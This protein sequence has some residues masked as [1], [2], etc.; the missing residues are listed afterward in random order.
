MVQQYHCHTQC[1]TCGAAVSVMFSGKPQQSQDLQNW[2]C[3]L[4]ARPPPRASCLGRAP[5]PVCG[6]VWDLQWLPSYLLAVSPTPFCC[7]S[8]SCSPLPQFPVK[9]GEQ[10]SSGLNTSLALELLVV[11]GFQTVKQANIRRQRPPFVRASRQAL[12]GHQCGPCSKPGD[13]GVQTTGTQSLNPLTAPFRGCWFHHAAMQC[14]APEAVQLSRNHQKWWWGAFQSAGSALQALL[15][16]P[17]ACERG[18][19]GAERPNQV[20]T[21]KVR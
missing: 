21:T 4:V 9:S 16:A 11:L 1:Y 13:P 12:I 6:T 20:Q 15:L 18:C 3:G 19:M 8:K 10:F 7:F 2:S 5:L 14:H 17:G